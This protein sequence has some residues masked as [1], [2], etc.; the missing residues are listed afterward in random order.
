MKYEIEAYLQFYGN[1]S[2]WVRVK[3]ICSWNKNSPSL[4]LP[5]FKNFLK[6]GSAGRLQRV[7]KRR[8]LPEKVHTTLF[9]QIFYFPFMS[10]Y[11]K[12]TF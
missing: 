11:L 8:K 5:S 4:L 3:L 12:R 7:K 2:L 9:K 6:L 1:F 10:L